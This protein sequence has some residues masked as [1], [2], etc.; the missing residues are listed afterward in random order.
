MKIINTTRQTVIADQVAIADTPLSRMIGLLNRKQI[1]PSEALVIESCNSIHMFFMRFSIDVI[2]VGKDNSVVGLV[3]NIK[4][5]SLSPIFWK[6]QRAIE[7]PAGTI[8]ASGTCL[9]DSI[10]QEG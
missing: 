9:G 1:L 2:F 6:A 10:T 3:K 4:P 5:F 7:L 8:Q